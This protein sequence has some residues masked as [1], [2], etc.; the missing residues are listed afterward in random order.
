MTQ[1][2]DFFES[3]KA[4]LEDAISHARGEISLKTTVIPDDPPLIDGLTIRKLRQQSS[5]SQTVFAKMLS[6]SAKTV[7]SWEQ[8]VR[9][10]HGSSLRLLQL[11][12]Q[13]PG[14]ICRTLGMPVVKLSGVSTTQRKG[15]QHLIVSK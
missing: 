4:G 9:T 13:N 1:S 3:V 14:E 12:A 11:F 15:K 7:Q 6:V 8:G 5:M 2:S 10:P